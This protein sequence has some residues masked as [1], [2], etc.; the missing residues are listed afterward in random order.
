VL[1]RPTSPDCAACPLETSCAWHGADA[2]DPAIGS[3]GVS[4][5]Q[6]RFEG[7][8][9]QAR[10][11]LLKALGAG[12]VRRAAAGMVMQ[13]PSELAGTLVDGLVADGLVVVDGSTLRLP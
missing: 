12:P 6:A 9:R 8:D 4:R 3:A 11:R 1:C 7:S 13:R 5:A 2:P 10:G